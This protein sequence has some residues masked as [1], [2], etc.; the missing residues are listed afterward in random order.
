MVA[1]L[2]KRSPRLSRTGR[3]HEY[4]LDILGLITELVR[5]FPIARALPVSL[6]AAFAVFLRTRIVHAD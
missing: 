1:C 6:N 4:E 3:F 2:T 5:S